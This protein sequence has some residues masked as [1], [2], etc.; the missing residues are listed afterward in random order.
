MAHSTGNAG[1]AGGGECMRHAL[2]QCCG[3]KRSKQVGSGGW[4]QQRWARR[5]R[6]HLD[7]RRASRVEQLLHEVEGVL[8]PATVHGGDDGRVVGRVVG[9]LRARRGVKVV[10]ELQAAVVEGVRLSDPK[11]GRPRWTLFTGRRHRGVSSDC[12]VMGTV[13]M[14]CITCHAQCDSAAKRVRAASRVVFWHV[15]WRYCSIDM[16]NAR[17]FSVRL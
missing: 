11:A 17:T 3:L 4:A 5:S 7:V 9:P 13:R 2:I 12:V 6:A 14:L 10:S 8:Q 1:R 15:L 16:S